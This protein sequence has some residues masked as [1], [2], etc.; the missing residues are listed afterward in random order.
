MMTNEVTIDLNVLDAFMKNIIMGNVNSTTIVTVNMSIGGLGS[1]HVS[2]ELTKLEEFRGGI[3]ESMVL[4]FST[5]TSNNKLFLVTLRDR[6]GI[7]KEAVICGI[8]TNS[9][10]LSPVYI[11]IDA[12]LKGRLC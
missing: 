2:Q 3:G 10:I 11:N 6:R 8:A 5:R 9:G 1:T 4:S 7:Q 12:Q